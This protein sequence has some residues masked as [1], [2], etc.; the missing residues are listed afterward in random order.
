MQ[1]KSAISLISYDAEY[2]PA[3]I[4][5]YYAYVDEIIL[6]LDKNRKTW[7]G[8]SFKFDEQDLFKKLSVIDGDNKIT[9]VEEDF[10]K[11]N[12]FIE[13]DNYERNYLK[14]QCS[15]DWL[16]SF[17]ADEELLNANEFF[18]KFLP[19]VEPYYKEYDLAFNWFL[20]YKEFDDSYLVITDERGNWNLNETQGF[21]NWK[22][23]EFTYARWTNNAQG[24]KRVL[25]TPL[26]ILHWSIC[27]KD[28]E[29]NQKIHNIGHA[30]IADRDPFYDIWRNINL[31][32]FNELR[33]FKTSGFGDPSQWARLT[34]ISKE[35]F[36]KKAVE[37]ANMIGI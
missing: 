15:Y 31:G 8:N 21:A 29:L 22:N 30:D 7:A 32:N 12:V 10:Y 1:K 25:A 26:A 13:N 19:L 36:R 6:G 23:Y 27:R 4:M 37:Q 35:E 20:P 14:N 2:L 16:F 11:S 9:V 18:E 34:Q 28:Q 17:D 33:N 3:S 5:S 24:A